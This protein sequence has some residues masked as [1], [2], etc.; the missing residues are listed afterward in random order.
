MIKS[1]VHNSCATPG[2]YLRSLVEIFQVVLNRSVCDAFRLCFIDNRFR[3][4]RFI[5][6]TIGHVSGGTASE[7]GRRCTK[8]E[9]TVDLWVAKRSL[10]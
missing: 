4:D 8:T 7:E 10:V 2:Q 6:G 3:A 9:G 5:V 1:A